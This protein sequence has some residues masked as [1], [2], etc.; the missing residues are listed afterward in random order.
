MAVLSQPTNTIRLYEIVC[1]RTDFYSIDQLDL[2]GTDKVRTGVWQDTDRQTTVR[3]KSFGEHSNF[4]QG[5]VRLGLDSAATT[6]SGTRR[7]ANDFH[8]AVCRAVFRVPL[9][10]FVNCALGYSKTPFKES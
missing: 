1:N 10:D 2:I 6:T 8:A 3:L 4:H 5:T 7:I 9:F